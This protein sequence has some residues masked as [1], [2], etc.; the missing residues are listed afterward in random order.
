MKRITKEMKMMR[1]TMDSVFRTL[2]LLV[3][4]MLVTLG[5]VFLKSKLQKNR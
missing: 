3:I 2:T 1:N 5:E 4:Y